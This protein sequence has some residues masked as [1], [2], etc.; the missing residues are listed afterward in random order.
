MS[1]SKKDVDYIKELARLRVSEEEA[2]GLVKDLNS[3][4]KYVD[5]LNEVDTDAVEMLVNPLYIEN[6]YREDVVES[7]LTS[8]DFLMNAPERVEDYLKV[9]SV[10]DREEA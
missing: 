1:V 9:P 3:I 10:I 4:L 6:V 8:E 2:E 7:S 5:Q